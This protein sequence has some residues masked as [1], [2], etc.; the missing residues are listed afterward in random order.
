MTPEQ[1][2]EQL[3]DVWNVDPEAYFLDDG[4]AAQ[5]GSDGEGEAPSVYGPP[6][7]FLP[8]LGRL[9]ASHSCQRRDSRLLARTQ[10]I[11]LAGFRDH[12]PAMVSPPPWRGSRGS[13]ELP[14]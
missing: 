10:A 8:H 3:E 9:H 6:V 7:P 13:G 1:A 4:A 12:E 11:L 2:A 14:A 5:R